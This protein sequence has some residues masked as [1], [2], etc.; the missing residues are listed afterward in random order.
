MKTRWS[1][2]SMLLDI[3]EDLDISAFHCVPN[4]VEKS[5][6]EDMKRTLERLNKPKDQNSKCHKEYDLKIDQDC[7]SRYAPR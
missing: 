2:H 3:H 6:L 4:V 1:G 5:N 7:C